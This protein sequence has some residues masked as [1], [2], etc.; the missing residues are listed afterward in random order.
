MSQSIV[1]TGKFKCPEGFKEINFEIK[2]E[3]CEE[4]VK[5]EDNEL[6]LIQTPIEMDISSLENKRISLNK[7]T[8]FKGENS[9]QDGKNHE[10]SATEIIPENLLNY[11]LILPSKEHNKLKPVPVSFR[12]YLEVV[13]TLDLPNELNIKNVNKDIANFENLRQRFLPFGSNDAL[14][15]FIKNENVKKKKKRYH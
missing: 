9:L 15:L 11:Q 13:E 3:L 5:N 4:D 6:W 10:I 8:V 7:R 1:N 2:D 12:G 14:S